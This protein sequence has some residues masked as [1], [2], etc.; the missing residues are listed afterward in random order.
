[1]FE[2]VEERW[3][4]MFRDRCRPR[5]GGERRGKSEGGVYKDSKSGVE[6]EKKSG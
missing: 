5:G 4:Q 2:V 6:I 1:M 3:I